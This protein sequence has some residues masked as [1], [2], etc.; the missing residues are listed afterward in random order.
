M[1][2]GVVALALR[3]L[4]RR[5]RAERLGIGVAEWIAPDRE[6][7]GLRA[8]VLPDQATQIARPVAGPDH[9]RLLPAGALLGAGYLTVIDTIARSVLP[10]EIPVG[11]V[12]TVE[13]A[14]VFFVLLRRA[15]NRIWADA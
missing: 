13:G 9:R 4:R 12:T 3:R 14:P 2:V 5:L 15:R 7:G 8:A 10:A 11:V 6:H 1:I